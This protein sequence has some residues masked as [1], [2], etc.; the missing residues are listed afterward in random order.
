MTLGWFVYTRLKK[1]RDRRKDRELI[2]LVRLYEQNKRSQD[3]KLDVF[4]KHV[5]SNFQLLRRELITL[6][7]RITDDGVESAMHWFSRLFPDHPFAGQICT[8]ILAT[9]LLPP[10][11]AV[12]YLEQESHTIAQISGGLYME[13]WNTLSTVAT[14]VNALPSFMMFFLVIALVLY[15]ISTVK[16][17]LF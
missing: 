5:A 8:I 3:L 2:A 15:H 9:E 1:R 16:N 6:S 7:E 12:E 17:A 14:M 10:T 13:R 4:L 11:D